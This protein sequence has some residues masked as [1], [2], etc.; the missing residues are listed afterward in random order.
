MSSAEKIREK[1]MESFLED[2]EAP[3]TVQAFCKKWKI[4]VAD[5]QAHYSDLEDLAA[6]IP[7]A[8]LRELSESL[9]EQELF[10]NYGLREKLLAFYF[11][12]FEKYAENRDY[13]L[14]V[15]K[16]HKD[17]PQMFQ[18]MKRSRTAF[19]NFIEPMLRQ[20]EANSEIPS[21]KFISKG[22]K[23]IL[24]ADF[25]FVFQFWLKDNS[26]GFERTDAFIEKTLNLAMNVL[27]Q[28]TLDQLIDL[29]KFMFASNER[30]K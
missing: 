25:M 10:R 12:A 21:R 6:D 19:I 8:V 7:A 27:E 9:L 18:A 20:A 30:S 1:F 2:G 4:K 22:Y 29:G 5:F 13:Y 24:W 14:L 17:L 28:N 15:N 26:K 11:S 3:K 23:E 16:N